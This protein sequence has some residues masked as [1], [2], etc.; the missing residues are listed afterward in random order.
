MGAIAAVAIRLWPDPRGNAEQTRELGGGTGCGSVAT[1]LGLIALGLALAAV[2]ALAAL[3]ARGVPIFSAGTGFL[4]RPRAL[5]FASFACA[6]LL[7][8][9]MTSAEK[10]L[11][12]A[13]QHPSSVLPVQV[14]PPPGESGREAEHLPGV[15]YLAAGLDDR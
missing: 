14:W 13:P 4:A 12:P 9:A 5:I 6:G 8:A 11:R 1:E 10:T 15:V 7:A 2:F 3:S